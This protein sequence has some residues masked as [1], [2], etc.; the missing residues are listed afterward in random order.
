MTVIEDGVA[1]EGESA[2]CSA[3]SGRIAVDGAIIT[4]LAAI[5]CTVSTA[6]QR[7]IRAA[8]VRR[9]IGI[10]GACVAL[11]PGM[12]DAIAA[13]PRSSA[14]WSGGGLCYA[15]P[16]ASITCSQI[17]VVALLRAFA[18]AIA[19]T[20]VSSGGFRLA[21]SSAAV[22]TARVSVVTLFRILPNTVSTR[23]DWSCVMLLRAGARAAIAAR[24]VSV[25]ALFIGREDD[26]ISTDRI[27]A[28]MCAGII[29]IGIAVITLF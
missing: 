20:L 17:S 4:L 5:D 8:G 10:R 15:T 12:H 24:Q 7:A 28:E 21:A 11:F 29:P 27:L 9:A 13:D 26:A 23:C 22:V 16:G 19:T 14:N 2:A 1:A 25:I 6:R 3:G 18:D